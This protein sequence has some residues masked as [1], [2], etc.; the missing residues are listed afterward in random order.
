MTLSSHC[1]S[2]NIATLSPRHYRHTRHCRSPTVT[3][4]SSHCHSLN[5][6]TLSQCRHS[7]HCQ[8]CSHTVAASL[9]P[10]CSS[11]FFKKLPFLRLIPHC[12]S[13]TIVTLSRWHCSHC[14]SKVTVTI[15]TLS[16]PQYCQTVAVTLSSLLQHNCHHSV[17]TLSP[18][19]QIPNSI[20]IYIEDN[21]SKD[22]IF[23]FLF[24]KTLFPATYLHHKFTQRV[25][26]AAR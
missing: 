4:L 13:D 7:S 22:T 3:A 5:I 2:L 19:R 17:L 25:C 8:H 18:Q 26:L 21:K 15:V 10:K 23:I 24:Q 6:T 20:S 12:H 14:G 16:L 9:S 11:F 1:H